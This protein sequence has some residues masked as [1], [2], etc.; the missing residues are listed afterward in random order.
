M[1]NLKIYFTSDIHGYIFPTDYRDFDEKN[2]GLLNIISNFKKDGNTLII[3]GGDT[4]QGSPFT[5]YLSKNQFSFN[6][7]SEILNIGKY[8]FITLG[9]HD[10]NYGYDYLKNYLENLDATCICANIKDKTNKLPILPSSIKV[11]ENGLKIGLIGITTDFIPLWEQPKNLVNIQVMDTYSSI[12]QEISSLKDKV[13][14]LIGV[15]HGGFENNLETGDVLSTT[16]ENIAYKICSTL[17]LDLLLTG[18]QHMEIYNKNL[19]G[20]HIVQTPNNGTK[21]ATINITIDDDNNK[22]I[23]SSLEVP[24]INPNKEGL[25][26]LQSIEDKVQEWLDTPVGFLDT[27]LLP[28]TH[29]DMAINGSTL[30]NFI[31]SVQLHFSDAQIACTSFANSIKGFN[32]EVTIRDIVSTYIYP[33][34]LVVLE[35]TGTILKKALYRCSEYFHLNEN[36][37]LEISK[38]F[39]EP[40]I[41]HYNYDYFYNISYTFD[42][43]KTDSSR[44]SSVKYNGVEIEDTD[45]FSIVMNNYRTSGSGGFEFF[46]DAPIIKEIQIEMPELLI[47]Y[48]IKYKNISTNNKKSL[49]LIY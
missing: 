36:G 23:I 48:F 16:S 19:F 49:K 25:N 43:T 41:E 44:I 30:A 37:S 40:K 42:L 34:T 2:L 47:E 35:I 39:L 24:T 26:L 11:L 5:T 9:N 13:D 28:T 38:T 1:K 21:F 22:N 12:K 18:H 4:I 45:K 46:K 20:T 14:I 10:F 7:L 27:S 6:P 29:L 8:D 3:D 33:N 17:S 15:Y 31:N 32:K